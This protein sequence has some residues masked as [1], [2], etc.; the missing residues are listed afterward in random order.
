MNRIHQLDP[1]RSTGETK[2]LFEGVKSKF[3]KTS[4]AI[5]VLGNSPAALKG[6]L[7]LSRAL[8]DGVLP[9]R[10]REQIALT[11]AEINGCGYCLSFH[12]LAGRAAG[13]SEQDVIAARCSNAVDGKS[14]AA[15]KLARAIALHRGQI[16]DRDLQAARG[17]GLN[18]AEM[19]EV[20][21][22]VGLNTMTN[23]LNNV[24]RT[25][26]DF[27]EVRP[28]YFSDDTPAAATAR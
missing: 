8:A 23:F 12:T 10:L 14:D 5:R 9:A 27:P 11:V 21:L 4:N 1:A 17:A 13:L 16:A 25:V 22:H 6:Y 3:G 2:E 28:G 15:L 20:A 7:G 24:A 18:D 19:V 26:I